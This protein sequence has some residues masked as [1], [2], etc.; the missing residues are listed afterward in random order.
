MRGSSRALIAG[1]PDS[2]CT[3]VSPRE[4]LKILMPKP[5]PRRNESEALAGG[6]QTLM[7]FTNSSGDSKTK[8]VLRAAGLQEFLKH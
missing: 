8:P 2:G 3:S 5:N 6:A 7:I 1:V 4:L